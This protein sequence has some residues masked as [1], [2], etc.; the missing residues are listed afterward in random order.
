MINPKTA[1][2]TAA[3][4]NSFLAGAA[5][6]QRGQTIDPETLPAAARDYALHGQ[7]YDRDPLGHPASPGCIWSRLQ[8][9]TSQGLRWLDVE[10]CQPS[11][12]P[13]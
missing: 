11:D 8:V 2:F 10:D 1:L 7:L 4:L 9:P 13:P 6:A 12:G 3:F 5:F